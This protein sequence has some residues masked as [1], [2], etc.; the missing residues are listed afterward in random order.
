MKILCSICARKGSKGL[1]NKNIK[2][3]FGKPLIL[4]TIIQA[5]RT[6]LFDKIVC[7]SDSK[8]VRQ[9]ANKNGLDLVINRPKNLAK[10]KAPKIKTIKHLFKISEIFF[11]TK[12]DL[13]V[14]LDITA[15]LRSINDIK[16][17]INVIKNKNFPCNLVA[18][19]PSKKNPYFNMVEINKNG[20]LQKVKKINLTITS[21]Q[22]APRVYDIN[23]GIY[24][25]NRK[26]L[27][28]R[29]KI[30]NKNTCYYLTPPERSVDIDS[31]FDF[32]LVKYLYKRKLMRYN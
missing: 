9:L 28:T 31:S 16:N 6:K 29:K 17:S 22:S 18:I 20:R 4:H 12:F 32:E 15:P 21:R 26:G 23:A 14:D 24:I 8:F 25:W 19:S 30:I 1:K 13:I 27:I 5:K 2:L 7:S 11:K 10:D 3:F